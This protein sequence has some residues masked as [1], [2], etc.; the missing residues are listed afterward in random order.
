MMLLAIVVLTGCMYPDDLKAENNI[1]AQDQIESVQRA[2]EQFQQDTGVLPIK[3]S[4]V[5]TDLY[6]KYKI[7]F[8]QLVP[9]YLS[10]IPANAYE[11]GGLFQFVIWDAET[12]PTV[13]LID[14]RTPDKIR[15]V[16][17]RMMLKEYP[18]YGEEV[19]TG[20]YT[21]DYKSL[22]YENPLVV[23]SP[24]TTNQLPLVVTP[25]GEVYVDYTADIQQLFMT[26]KDVEKGE[27]L[28]NQLAQNYPVLPAYSLAYTI[29]E[30]DT[31][32][33]STK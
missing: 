28:R 30:N 25:K 26:F 18:P 19:A 12:N 22:G 8:E 17:A 31:I 24:F 1:P 9:K 4:D 10:Y 11:K 13:K 32:I 15:D 29:D 5:D 14:L 16:K 2:I 23:E 20:V 3:N 33:F 21:I 7:D 6:I 27:D